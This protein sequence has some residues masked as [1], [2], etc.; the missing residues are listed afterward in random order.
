MSSAAA[1][2]VSRSLPQ[3]ALSS[4]LLHPRFSEGPGFTPELEVKGT[5]NVG[6]NSQVHLPI[7]TRPAEQAPESQRHADQVT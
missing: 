4:R 6:S 1:A 2:S 3:P 5:D 7:V